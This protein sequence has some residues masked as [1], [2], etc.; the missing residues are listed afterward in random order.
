[1]TMNILDGRYDMLIELLSRPTAP[2]REH[3][4][5]RQIG[6][7]LERGRVP[8]FQDTSGNWVVGV[9]SPAAYKRLLCETGETL[10]FF[11]AH[12]DH[13]GFHGARWVT[14]EDLEIKWHGGAPAKHVQGAR[15]WLA[16]ERAHLGDGFFTEVVLDASK[17][18]LMGG[19]IHVNFALSPRPRANTL[20][21]GFAFRAPVWRSGKRLY[22][23]AADDLIGVFALLNTA[24]T[25]YRRRT[26]AAPAFLGLITR[27]EEVGF[28]GALAHFDLGWLAAARRPLMCISLEASRTLPG[29]C[30]GKGPI[31]RLGDKCTVFSAQG[32]AV[33]T[34]LAARLLPNAHQR[35]I[36]DGGACE[37]TAAIAY[38]LPAIG[39]SVPLGNYHNQGLEGGPDCAHAL[40]PA[41]EFVH[42]D[43]VAGMLTLCTGLMQKD[44]P[45]PDA[46]AQQRQRLQK[47]LHK[48]RPLL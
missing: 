44:L 34:E 32:I 24:L 19:N 29:A 45:W 26:S 6:E 14:P 27:A 21:G 10:K 30:I 38:G 48:Y 33:L 1:M 13:P 35:R 2:F 39:I 7:I 43:D 23:Q 11:I 17:R 9:A 28:V 16:N 40:G 3:H 37:A 15:V 18:R 47:T 12:M 42:L 31:V 41:P 25:L 4:V 22:T 20:F 8:A 46:F 36:M 5:I